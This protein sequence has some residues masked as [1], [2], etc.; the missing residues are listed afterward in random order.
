M[1][2]FAED[3]VRPR[4]I[5]DIQH[6][7]KKYIKKECQAV[8]PY[9]HALLTMGTVRRCGPGPLCWVKTA[10]AI[11]IPLYLSGSSGLSGWQGD[12]QT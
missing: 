8:L 10:H 11:N 5:T 4:H 12:W 6:N 2:D 9:F 1:S 7:C 3:G